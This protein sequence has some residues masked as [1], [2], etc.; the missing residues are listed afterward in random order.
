MNR[1]RWYGP[2]L[3][4]LVAVVLVMVAGPYLAQQIAWAQAGA[5]ITLIRDSLSQN[6]SLATLSEAFRHVAEVVEPSVVHIQIEQKGGGPGERITEEDL[7]RRFF[8]PHPFDLEPRRRRTPRSDE[9]PDEQQEDQN[10]DRFNVP[11]VVGAG[12]GWVY[13]SQ[14]HVITNHHVVKDADAITVRFQDGTE[15]QATVVGTDPKTDIAVLKIE[16]GVLHPATLATEPVEQGDIVF[17]F[18]SPLGFE[19]S[20]SQGIVSAKGRQ[21]RILTDGGYENFIQTDAAINRGN[22]GGPM[23]NIY[24]QVVGMNAAIASRS[25]GFQGLGFAIPVST[26]KHVVGQLIEDGKVSRGY[27]GI[28]IADLDPKLARTFGYDGTGVLV[29]DPI[30]DGPAAA[31]GIRRGDIITKLNGQSVQTANELRHK[32]AAHRPGTRLSLEVFRDGKMVDL[33]VTIAQ[34]PD[35]VDGRGGRDGEG[36]SQG[37]DDDSGRLLLRKLGLRSVNTM[38]PQIAKRFG[39]KMVPGVLVRSVRRESAADA[40]GITEGQII[41]DV[42]GVKVETV[43]ELVKEL[44]KHDI[45]EGV[46]LS[47]VDGDLERFVF[48]E[49]PDK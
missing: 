17:A 36:R 24:G 33:E 42:M 32:V 18:G 15:R 2:T 49:L 12:S 5:R 26:L 38:D 13:D 45:S 9:E 37:T 31:A 39:A 16:G 10:L 48:L 7:L 25:T 22:S 43:D 23:T 44:K 19:F 20:M 14:G 3:V 30:E 4:L 11:R 21:L 27:L 6:P 35:E 40:A 29:E 41:T 8:G 46:R 1:I 28:Y 47:V 34:L